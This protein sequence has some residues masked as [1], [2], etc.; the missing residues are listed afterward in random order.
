MSASI[1]PML[2]AGDALA[3]G[4]GI[5]VA[6][7]DEALR[8]CRAFIADLQHPADPEVRELLGLIDR[9]LGVKS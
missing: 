2:T 1:L 8:H 4:Y 5:P 7:K 6:V 9:A 3:S